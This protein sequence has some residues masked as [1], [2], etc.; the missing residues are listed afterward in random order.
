VFA[1][2]L[3]AS[4]LLLIA[5]CWIPEDFDAQVYVNKEGS[6][7]FI[8]EGKLAKVMALSLKK[9]GKIGKRKRMS[10]KGC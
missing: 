5:G 10:L 3:L 2:I 1:L 9:E 8:Y 4:I 7:R 6:Y